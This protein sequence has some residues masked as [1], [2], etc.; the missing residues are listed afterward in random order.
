MGVVRVRIVAMMMS[1]N[2]L[3]SARVQ[4]GQRVEVVQCGYDL[5]MALR[6][7]ASAAY[8]RFGNE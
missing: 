6:P 2:S 1:I 3:P 5:Q 4:P 8:P 7:N